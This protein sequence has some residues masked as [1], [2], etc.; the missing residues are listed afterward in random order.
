MENAVVTW[1]F[2]LLTFLSPPAQT[3]CR[4]PGWE[5]TVESRT[6]RYESIAKDLYEVIYTE[7]TKTPYGGKRGRAHTVA[8]MVALAYMES[9]FMPDVDRGPCYRGPG[10]RARCDGGL[11][12]TMWQIRIGAGT[13]IDTIHGTPDLDQ[14]D[15][16]RDRKAA[17]RAALHMVNRSFRAARMLGPEDRLN[18]Y[19]SGRVGAG[20]A[21]GKA[22]LDLAHRLLVNR[23]V[24]W[25]SDKTFLIPLVDTG[26]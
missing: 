23:A 16:F 21:A 26:S 24:S 8:L 13:T 17:I 5:E 9:G 2:G 3:T 10:F 18:V 14:A 7:K 20:Q 12:A 11:S 15:L 22:R 6:Q 19:G 1:I 25:E 4:L